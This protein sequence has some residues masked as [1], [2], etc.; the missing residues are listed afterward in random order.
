MKYAITAEDLQTIFDY[1][2]LEADIKADAD[3]LVLETDAGH[4]HF[5][6]AFKRTK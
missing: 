4:G 6:T 1:L 5:T 2:G 3:E